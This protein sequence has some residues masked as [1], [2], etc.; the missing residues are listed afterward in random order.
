MNSD[1][2][3]ARNKRHDELPPALRFLAMTN[4]IV[5]SWVKLFVDGTISYH[6]AM[7]GIIVTLAGKNEEL[8]AKYLKIQESMAYR[9]V[10][11][12]VP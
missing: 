10:T 4:P 7:E 5:D 12:T 11:R 2:E 8:E 6:K 9:P 3:L 1:Q